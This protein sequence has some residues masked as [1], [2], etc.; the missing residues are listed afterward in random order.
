MPKIRLKNHA[1]VLAY[2]L[3]PNHFHLLVKQ[4][5][6]QG[7]SEVL[8]VTT[9][10]YAMHFNQHYKRIGPLFQG[11]FRAKLVETDSYLLQLSKYIHRNPLGLPTLHTN[12][13]AYT[14]SSYPEYLGLRRPR[15]TKPQEILGLLALESP[16]LSYKEFVEKND[17]E[18]DQLTDMLFDD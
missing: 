15:F 12:L 6:D 3:M 1:S 14:F 5:K 2:A 13:C 17:V 8:R 18:I 4:E 10:T 9:L 11:R 7:I 16:G